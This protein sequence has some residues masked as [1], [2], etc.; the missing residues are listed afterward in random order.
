MDMSDEE[1]DRGE[2]REKG[3][4]TDNGDFSGD[5]PRPIERGEKDFVSV[6][7]NSFN[8]AIRRELQYLDRVV[9]IP[10]RVVRRR[11]GENQTS[12]A[13]GLE[14]LTW[15][16]EGMARVPVKMLQAAFGEDFSKSDQK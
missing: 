16:A 4:I 6:P 15:A 13:Q 10:F 12:W 2:Q 1:K 5:Q 7:V 9:A 14:E 8:E 11:V 3:N